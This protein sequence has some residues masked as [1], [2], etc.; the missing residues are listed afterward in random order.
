MRVRH[1]QEVYRHIRAAGGVC[2]S[3]E[4]QSGFG[5]AGCGK[6]WGFELQGVVP[7]IVTMG[8]PMGNGFPLAAVVTRVEIAQVHE[9]ARTRTRDSTYARLHSVQ[10]MYAF[11]NMSCAQN[12]EY[13]NVRER[14]VCF[15]CCFV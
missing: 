13:S 7:D 2:V 15:K 3:D 11:R 8:K 5:R 14:D 1:R 12:H 10:T 4:V 9:H 6:M